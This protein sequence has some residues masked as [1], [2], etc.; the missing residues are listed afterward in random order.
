MPLTVQERI[1]ARFGQTKGFVRTSC[2]AEEVFRKNFAY[3]DLPT[4]KANETTN[5]RRNKMFS[6]V[7]GQAIGEDN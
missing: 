6:G 7:I 5:F 2:E 1:E 4:F 3:R